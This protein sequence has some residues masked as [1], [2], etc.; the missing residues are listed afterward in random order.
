MGRKY[1]ASDEE[2]MVAAAEIKY[3]YRGIVAA[4]IGFLIFI[5]LVSRC[6]V[7]R[8][9]D[10]VLHPKPHQ[11]SNYELCVTNGGTWKQGSYNTGDCKIPPK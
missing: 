9:H 10:D 4:I 7:E 1:I 3:L 11:P 2:A 6:S 8:H 5:A